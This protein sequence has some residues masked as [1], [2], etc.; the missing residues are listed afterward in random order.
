MRKEIKKT[1]LFS[2][3][4]LFLFTAVVSVD[5][6]YY[7]TSF[8]NTKVTTEKQPESKELAKERKQRGEN[9]DKE[10]KDK[11]ENKDIAKAGGGDLEK[12][13]VSKPV[14][15]QSTPQPKPQINTYQQRPAQNQN[16]SRGYS[17][18]DVYWLARIIH[19]E[20]EG[21]SFIGKIA[22]G[23]VILNRVKSPD[24]PNSIYGVIF[25]KQ[26]GYTQFSPVL[27]GRIYNTPDNES[28]RAAQAAIDGQRP[29]GPALYFLNPSKSQNFWIPNN[30]QYMMSLGQHQFYY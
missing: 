1:V 25:D 4:V 14:V 16:L 21:E 10:N 23:S 19:A 13:P 27:D 17:R 22:V 18:D 28:Y 9:K 26:Y 2:I 12:Q 6:L 24:F 20:S 30:R 11:N 8:K 29:V 5:K 7:G 3:I 15:T